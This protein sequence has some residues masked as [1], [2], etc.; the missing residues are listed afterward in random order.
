[1]ETPLGTFRIRPDDATGERVVERQT[2]DGWFSLYGWDEEAVT[3]ADIA[4]ANILCSTNEASPFPAHLMLNVVRNEARAS[5][6][7]L[8][9]TEGAS[10]RTIRSGA[11]LHDVLA[12]VFRLPVGA[13]LGAALWTRLSLSAAVAEAA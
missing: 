8:R 5:L 12:H 11:E 3:W 9:L 4:E 1:V 10:Q 7:D 13:E 6:F 2:P